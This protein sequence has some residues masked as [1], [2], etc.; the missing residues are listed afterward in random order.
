MLAPVF[1]SASFLTGCGLK[2]KWF[3]MYTKYR[4]LSNSPILD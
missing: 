3:Y 2:A 1:S 4:T